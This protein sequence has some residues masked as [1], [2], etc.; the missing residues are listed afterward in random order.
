MTDDTSPRPR[1]TR[2]GARSPTPVRDNPARR[3][4]EALIDDRV[5]GVAEY[6]V[7]A[8]EIVFTHTEVDPAHRGTRVAIDLARYALD[9]ARERRLR[10]VPACSFIARFIRV[11]R[12][13]EDL[14]AG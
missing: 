11:H 6:H 13:Y 7:A 3:R 10:V 4:F 12:E 2:P 8:G 5:V 14:L 1:A 9:A